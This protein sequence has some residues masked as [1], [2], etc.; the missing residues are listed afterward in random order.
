[1]GAPA[2]PIVAAQKECTPSRVPLY[3]LGKRTVENKN[4]QK[5]IAAPVRAGKFEIEKSE[6]SEKREKSEKS[7]KREKRERSEKIEK[8]PSTST[9]ANDSRVWEEKRYVE[10]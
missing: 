7:E 5:D 8:I 9:G 10:W 2:K 4:A 1:M 3:L 6:R